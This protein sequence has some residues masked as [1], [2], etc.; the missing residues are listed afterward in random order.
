MAVRIRLKRTGARNAAS[1][2]VVAADT[3]SPRDGRFLETLGWY[4]PNRR[5]G[6]NCRIDIERIEDWVRRGAQVSDTVRSLV[7]QTRRSAGQP[8]A[9]EDPAA[10]EAAKAAETPDAAVPPE[11]PAAGDVP[12][13]EPADEDKSEG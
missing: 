13:A 6:E 3:R 11:S 7:K 8:V 10:S 5:P 1:Y 2:R 12:A 9:E 4:D